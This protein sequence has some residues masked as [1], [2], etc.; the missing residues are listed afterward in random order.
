MRATLASG[1]CVEGQVYAYDGQLGLAVL[2]KAGVT[3]HAHDLRIL[4]TTSVRSVA[5]LREAPSG[6]GEE[7][8][9]QVDYSMLQSRVDQAVKRSKEEIANVNESVDQ[10]VQVLPITSILFPFFP[11]ERKGP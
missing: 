4:S 7:A 2:S 3:P 5:K 8:L 9:P 10:G 1:D 6:Y 11:S